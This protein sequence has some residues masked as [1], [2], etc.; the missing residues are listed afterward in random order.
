MLPNHTLLGDNAYTKKPYMATPISGSVNGIE[1]AYSFYHSQLHITIERVF[2]MLAH[3][4]GILRRPVS[5]P[6][7]NVGP[8]MMCLCRLHNY[9]TGRSDS[10][11]LPNP[12]R[13]DE[14]DIREEARDFE[15]ELVNLDVA[16]RPDSLLAAGQH[17]GDV[18]H[19]EVLLQEFQERCS[20]DIML[21]MVRERSLMDTILNMV[22]KQDLNHPS[23]P[24]RK[25]K[26]K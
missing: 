20:M 1:D 2:G 9:C 22:Q 17:F 24:S 6:M 11:V 16:G 4:W 15:S 23:I 19:Q 8:L 25:R 14:D 5:C 26:R 7:E 18:S 3:R 21:D 12:D 13:D 10:N